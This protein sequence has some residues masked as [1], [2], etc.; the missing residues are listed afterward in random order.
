MVENSF[1]LGQKRGFSHFI[2]HVKRRRRGPEELSDRSISKCGRSLIL[3]KNLKSS[4]FKLFPEKLF[5]ND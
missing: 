3:D 1:S 5:S 2:L 4:V